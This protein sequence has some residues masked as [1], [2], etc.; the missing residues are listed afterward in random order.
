MSA[1]I[2]ILREALTDE[3]LRAFGLP[4]TNWSRRSIFWLFRGLI[5]QFAQGGLTFD[6]LVADQGFQPAAA[7]LLE[8][9]CTRVS[10]CGQETIP[11]AGPLLVVSNHPGS[12]DVLLLMASLRRPDVKLISNNI[13]F[14]Q[15]LPAT[16]AHLIYGA[17]TIDIT[18]RMSAVRLALR[19]LQGGGALILMGTGLIDPDPE[20]HPDAAQSMDSWSPSMELFLR[21]VPEARVVLAVVSGVLSPR[22]VHHPITW[23]RKEPRR[24]RL[25]AEI[26]QIAHQALFPRLRY[27]SPHLSFAPPVSLP[28]LQQE[29]QSDRVL[30]V[31]ITHAKGL[32]I[33]HMG[34]VMS[35]K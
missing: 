29:A 35:K 23:L 1:D 18:R 19:H 17:R 33:Q 31:L 30:P 14:L 26:A 34:M 22:W 2:N 10:V 21:Q 13:P 6:Q 20:V 24:K 7:W 5:E 25:L 9:F 32:L 12:I 8:R 16:S 4:K 3:L 15:R 11:F 27:L 28:D